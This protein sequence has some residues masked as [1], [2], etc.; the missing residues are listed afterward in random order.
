MQFYCIPRKLDA[1]PFLVI[2]DLAK[3]YR[4]EQSSL[5][6]IYG[7]SSHREHMTTTL[8]KIN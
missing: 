3:Q 4:E 1:I 8:E 6:S 7:D 2:P 5:V